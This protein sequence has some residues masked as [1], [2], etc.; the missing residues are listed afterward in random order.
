M[1]IVNWITERQVLVYLQ[2]SC[3]DKVDSEL[4]SNTLLISFKDAVRGPVALIQLRAHRCCCSVFGGGACLQNRNRT[5]L[6][7]FPELPAIKGL[8]IQPKL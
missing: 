6:F 4:G 7:L 3:G 2:Q 5:W 8:E 1:W